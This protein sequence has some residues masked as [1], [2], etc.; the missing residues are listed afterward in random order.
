MYASATAIIRESSGMS[1][2]GQTIRIS[3]TVHPLVMVPHHC[4]D[5]SV[6]IDVG[7]DPL[8]DLRMTL[9]LTSLIERQGAWL[10][11]ETRR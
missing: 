4:R 7:E 11:E 5:L 2:P 1:S 8:T 6:R 3:L 9:H 10:L